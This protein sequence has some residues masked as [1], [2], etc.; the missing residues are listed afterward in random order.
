MVWVARRE[1]DDN[2]VSTSARL[3]LHAKVVD[4]TL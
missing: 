1:L 3:L 4:S 2:D